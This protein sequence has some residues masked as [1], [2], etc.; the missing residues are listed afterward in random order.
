MMAPYQSNGR[1]TLLLDRQF[2]GIGRVRRASGTDD[3]AEFREIN[4]LLTKL[5]RRRRF[6][7][8]EAVRDGRIHPLDLY[9]QV[10]RHGLGSLED[11]PA[12]EDAV[13][14]AD[15]W[16][17]W[18]AV[19]PRANTARMYRGAW[20]HLLVAARLRDRKGAT[21]ADVSAELR[22]EEKKGTT[23]PAPLL[24]LADLAPLLL[25]LRAAMISHAP[26]FN[27]TRASVQAFVKRQVGTK[28]AVYLALEGVEKLRE[29]AKRREGLPVE[30]C[31]A[32]RD[33]LPAEAAQG[34]WQL[35]TSGMR[36]G[37]YYEMEKASWSVEGKLLVIDGGK[38][39]YSVRVVPRLGDAFKPTMTLK[40]FRA[41]LKELKVTPHVAR[42][43]FKVL[44]E[45]AGI[46]ENRVEQY[47]GRTVKGMSGL[48]SR[49]N[50]REWADQDRE[51]LQRYIALA[52]QK[53]QNT[54][55]EEL[56]SA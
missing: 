40:N 33:T 32:H 44:A 42:Y 13:S 14:V 15:A 31:M 55:K 10:E 45:D 8:L 29:R 4:A 38:T 6:D 16:E 3:L 37:E 54:R 53:R 46:P 50:L 48:Y 51:A 24:G 36:I 49:V 21:F 9:L 56:R 17:E 20:R 30:Q 12:A 52:E 43:S 26:A 27:R 11:L 25:V 5:Y 18:C 7:Y 2:T 22:E 47:M 28:H 35:V 23:P 19:T 41:A 39:E 34:W 1:G